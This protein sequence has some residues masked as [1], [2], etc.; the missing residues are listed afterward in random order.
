MSKC[1]VVDIMLQVVITVIGHRHHAYSV[2][3][4][5]YAD[6]ASSRTRTLS[7]YQVRHCCF[8]LPDGCA[9]SGASVAKRLKPQF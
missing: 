1:I 3:V 4:I 9:G 8:G 7:K 5:R 6:V 2:F